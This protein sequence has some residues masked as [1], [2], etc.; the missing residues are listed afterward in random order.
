MNFSTVSSH[1]KNSTYNAKK[2]IHKHEHLEEKRFT[3]VHNIS[4]L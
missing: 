1:V 4:K 3:S 2:Y